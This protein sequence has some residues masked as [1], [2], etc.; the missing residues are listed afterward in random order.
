MPLD[1]RKEKREAYLFTTINL[2]I[3]KSCVKV[4]SSFKIHKKTMPEVYNLFTLTHIIEEI[5]DGYS[6]PEIHSAMKKM[7]EA[8]VLDVREREM[9]GGKGKII[10]YP[11]ANFKIKMEE[12]EENE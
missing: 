2:I 12:D 9:D 11:I 6:I 10:Y 3:M 7:V 4:L 1:I 5:E 8:G